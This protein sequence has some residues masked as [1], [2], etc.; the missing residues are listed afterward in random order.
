MSEA[1]RSVEVQTVFRKD[2]VETK[3]VVVDN[4][5]CRSSKMEAASLGTL[6]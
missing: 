1:D 4:D 2:H 5:A 6:M 3:H